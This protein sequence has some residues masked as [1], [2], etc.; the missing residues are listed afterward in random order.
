M[1]ALERAENNRSVGGYNVNWKK[2]RIIDKEEQRKRQRSAEMERRVVAGRRVL[3]E[4]VK[5]RERAGRQARGREQQ[6]DER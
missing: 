6:G 3:I 5:E 1:A 4:A 2:N